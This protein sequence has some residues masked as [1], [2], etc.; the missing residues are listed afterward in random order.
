[1]AWLEKSGYEIVRLPL[2]P[3][4][5]VSLEQL[6]QALEQPAALISLI[7]VSNETGAVNQAADIVRLRAAARSQAAIHLDAVQTTGKLAFDFIRSGVDMISGSGHKIG[8]PKGIGWLVKG[9]NI[10]L[11]AQIHGGGQQDGL[12]SGTENPPAA[13]AL[14]VALAEAILDLPGKIAYVQRLRDLFLDE[15]HQS[16]MKP[17]VFSPTD[18][19]P[20]IL[21]LAFPG[22]RGETMMHALEARDISISTGSACSSRHSRRGNKVLRAMGVRDD[23]AACAIRVS[24]AP[25][26]HEDEIRAVARAMA[27]IHRQLSR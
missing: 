22:L 27:D 6:A 11:Q 8:A 26:N 2:T 4:G 19:V 1:L 16:G 5:S 23:L 21:S 3:N 9:A 25:S 14:S 24:F 10:R 20:H 12:R 17:V 18:G 7:H 15:L 13:L